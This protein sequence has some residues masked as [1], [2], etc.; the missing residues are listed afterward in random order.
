MGLKF[1]NNVLTKEFKSSYIFIMENN[2]IIS[3]CMIV[4]NEELVLDR[5]L[6][7]VKNLV[8]EIIIVDTGSTDDTKNIAKKYTDKIYDFEWADDFSLA[9]NFAFS[10]ASCKYI[11]W[12]D[13]DDIVPQKTIKNLLKIKNSLSADT[14][15][16]TYE[17]PI[18]KNN[19]FSFYRERII[20]NCDKAKWHGAVHECIIPFGKIEYLNLPIIH[21]KEKV[22]NPKRNLQIYEKVLKQRELTPRE[23]YYYGRELFDSKQYKKAITILSK[24]SE[25]PTCREN[26]IDAYLYISNSYKIL[27]NYK[28]EKKFL[29]KTLEVDIP[30]AQ[31]CCLIGDYFLKQKNYT[32]ANFWYR[33]A[34]SSKKNEQSLAFV[35]DI[36]YSYYPNLQLCVSYYNLGNISTSIY[37]NERAAKSIESDVVKNNRKILQDLKNKKE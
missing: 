11:M 21:K 30:N 15:M 27:K 26:L 5:C 36:Y 6:S 3:L 32:Q 23:L 25:N 18:S 4:K 10:K 28:E 14:Y 24:F 22:S 34:L 7:S 16:L 13:A 12:L 35:N 1:N 2:K 29:F 8:D 9:R 20:K 17:I 37:F 31:V 19:S 33:Q